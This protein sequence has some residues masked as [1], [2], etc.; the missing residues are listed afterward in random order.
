MLDA[1]PNRLC[2]R[3]RVGNMPPVAAEPCPDTLSFSDSC[4]A[5]RPTFHTET[6]RLAEIILSPRSGNLRTLG[7]IDV[8]QIVA[9]SEPAYLRLDDIQHRA[10][11]VTCPADA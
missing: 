9:F 2:K 5:P 1:G 3:D 8:K 7:V 10:D 6:P 4:P 11:V